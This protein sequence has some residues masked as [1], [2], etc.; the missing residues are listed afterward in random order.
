MSAETTVTN[1]QQLALDV[2]FPDGYTRTVTMQVFVEG[3]APIGVLTPARH[4]FGTIKGEQVTTV[5]SWGPRRRT[6]P[7]PPPPPP[8]PPPATPPPGAPVNVTPPD[9]TTQPPTS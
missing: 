4:T 8:P 5:T 1:P 6:V 2:D 7:N 3:R 9:I